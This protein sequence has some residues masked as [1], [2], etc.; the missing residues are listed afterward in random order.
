MKK[1]IAIGLA[2]ALTGILGCQTLCFGALKQR[3]EEADL[4]AELD[5][6]SILECMFIGKSI[7]DDGTEYGDI[8]ENTSEMLVSFFT[9][10]GGNETLTAEEIREL[11]DYSYEYGFSSDIFSILLDV[12]GDGSAT[13][14]EAVKNVFHQQAIK[15]KD[16]DSLLLEIGNFPEAAFTYKDNWY[17]GTDGD[18]I[19]M[20]DSVLE[21]LESADVETFGYDGALMAQQLNDYYDENAGDSVLYLILDI[22]GQKELYSTVTDCIVMAVRDSF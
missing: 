6:Y 21:I 22:L 9:E 15:S 18:R 7:W 13:Y 19:A 4:L 1:R 16:L 5:D 12:Y 2:V 14:Q 17:A 20:V 10:A 3:S 8:K 11:I